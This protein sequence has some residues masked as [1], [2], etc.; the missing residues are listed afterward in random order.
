MSKVR[1][2]YQ[3]PLSKLDRFK[4]FVNANRDA[5]VEKMY[6]YLQ[7]YGIKKF[8]CKRIV[9]ARI[10]FARKHKKFYFTDFT[11]LT[12]GA[13]IGYYLA[14]IRHEYSLYYDDVCERCKFLTQN[15]SIMYNHNDVM[16]IW[17]YLHPDDYKRYINRVS[18]FDGETEEVD[19]G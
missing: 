1:I 11:E 7:K 12:N 10:A 17:S 2:Y 3:E 9:N 5:W 15:E 13:A 16:I 14:Y 8:M 4:N 18:K 6:L 19:D